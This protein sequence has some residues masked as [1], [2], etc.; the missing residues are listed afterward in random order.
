MYF[1]CVWCAAKP[2]FHRPKEHKQA[3]ALVI[4]QYYPR[5]I[6]ST[7]FDSMLDVTASGHCM[8]DLVRL[9]RFDEK[10][11]TGSKVCKEWLANIFRVSD[12]G[13]LR[14]NARLVRM[15]G[16]S[17][18]MAVDASSFVVLSVKEAVASL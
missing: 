14:Y 8:A 11:F 9:G 17:M 1:E 5:S 7:P 12:L 13:Q 3:S 6:Q 2:G 10:T 4:D 15:P 18:E 16:S